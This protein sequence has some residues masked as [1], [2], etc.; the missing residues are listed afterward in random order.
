MD[1]RGISPHA[2]GEI[3][4]S[5]TRLGIRLEK[6]GI[7]VDGENVTGSI[8]SARVDRI[9]SGYAASRAVRNALLGLQR[10]QALYSDLIVDGRDTGSVVFPDADMKFFLTASPRARAERRYKELLR[11]GEVIVYEEVLA[12]IRERDNAD[13]RREIAPLMEPEGAIHVDSSLMD[14]E[15]VVGKLAFIIQR[16]M[17]MYGDSR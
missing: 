15:D 12:Q 10:E 8:R 5:L 16:Q 6:N 9:V 7:F 11:K 17:A 1:S 13:S 2:E 4:Y 14:E 3:A